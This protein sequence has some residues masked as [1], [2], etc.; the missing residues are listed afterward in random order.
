MRNRLVFIA[1]AAGLMLAV[2]SAYLFSRQPQPQPP[3]FNP[4]A[5][6]FSRGIYADGMIESDQA[7]G[8][9]INIYPEVAGPI[10]SIV[11]TEGQRVK[12]GDALLSLDDSVQR[13]L[14]GQQQAQAQAAHAMLQEL[15]AQPRR[16]NL[17]VAAAQVESARANLKSAEDQLS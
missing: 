9:N 10:T 12:R 15:H 2:I 1:S 17:A 8:E 5:N 7:Q 16:E 3:L 11:V 14:T 6:P 4:A 13:A